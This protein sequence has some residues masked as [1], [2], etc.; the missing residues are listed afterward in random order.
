MSS[1]KPDSQLFRRLQL[2]IQIVLTVLSR[3]HP[4]DFGKLRVKIILRLKPHLFRN[5]GHGQAG[6]EQQ[7]LGLADSAAKQILH[8]RVSAGLLKDMRQVIGA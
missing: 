6:C 7:V 3:R 4:Y 5:L 8:G 1:E 2:L